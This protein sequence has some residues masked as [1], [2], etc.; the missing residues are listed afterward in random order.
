VFSQGPHTSITE[1]TDLKD[2]TQPSQLEM[3]KVCHAFYSKL[4]RQK[5][6]LANAATDQASL[7]GGYRNK[8]SPTM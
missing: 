8:L 1:L 5:E 2:C 7:L 4:Y 3:E 6:D